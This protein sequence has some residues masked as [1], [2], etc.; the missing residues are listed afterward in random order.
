MSEESPLKNQIINKTNSLQEK[1][2]NP[3]YNNPIN[4]SDS[5]SNLLNI[6]SIPKKP[7]ANRVLYVRPAYPTES[8]YK[9]INKEISE[10]FTIPEKYLLSDGPITLGKKYTQKDWETPTKNTSRP[11]RF[12]MMGNINKTISSSTNKNNNTNNNKNISVLKINNKIDASNNNIDLKMKYELIDNE[13]LADLFNSFKNNSEKKNSKI[14]YDDMKNYRKI[15]Q[16][17]SHSLCIQN[18]KLLDQS[19]NELKNQKM[20]KFLSKKLNI[21]ENQL[22][23]NN[24]D[25][26]R[27]KNDVLNEI[28]YGKPSEE[29]FGPFKWNLSLRMSEKF[30]GVRDYYFN[31]KQKEEPLWAVVPERKPKKREISLK[32]R[33]SNEGEEGNE[34]NEFN[35]DFNVFK[36]NKFLRP[37]KH[38]AKVNSVENIH[39]MN[40]K[41][42]NLYD[43]E[44]QREIMNSTKNR[45]KILHKIF[46]EN[47]K[48]VFNSEINNVFGNETLY[49]NYQK[50]NNNKSRNR[51]EYDE[52]VKSRSGKMKRKYFSIFNG[53]NF[54]KGL[55]TDRYG[56]KE[57]KAP[58]D[59]S[60]I[61]NT[62]FGKGFI[63]NTE[64]NMNNMN[65]TEEDKFN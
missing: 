58:G 46:V 18:Q 65:N 51:F 15:P 11:K 20:S 57:E 19:L 64:G 13:K 17:I 61:R 21:K 63:I 50:E 7:T 40:I 4:I 28:E 56:N 49:K 5:N 47:G 16:N 2:E 1:P 39:K 24:V 10:F 12:S 29:K 55:T 43:V 9:E 3:S 37:E 48:I 26:Y 54:R 31:V 60:E 22:L 33:Y 45:K 62:K 52:M 8:N 35:L 42:K 36:K 38:S 25:S 32:P 53:D 44:Y 23:F 6:N 30:R 41:G 34:E 27:M 14:F 59:V